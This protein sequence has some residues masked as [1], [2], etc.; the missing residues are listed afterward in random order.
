MLPSTDPAGLLTAVISA[1]AFTF[2]IVWGVRSKRGR[3]NP[4]Q[5]L[6]SVFFDDYYPE[7][8]PLFYSAS[9]K[10]GLPGRGLAASI[11]LH[12][13][14]LLSLPL[15]PYIFHEKI[16]FQFKNYQ[17]KIMEVRIPQPLM[18]TPPPRPTQKRDLARTAARLATRSPA[19][20]KAA[21]RIIAP[22]QDQQVSTAAAPPRRF[23]LPKSPRAR[24]RDVVIQPDQ[25]PET[26]MAIQHSL[27][28]ALLWAQRPAPPDES[29]LVGST[30]EQKPPLRPFS[31][32]RSLPVVQKP[33]RELQVR[34]VQ[35]GAGPVLTF[36]PPK[37][38]MPPANIAPLSLPPQELAPPGELP[39]SALP[40]GAPINLIALMNTP[41]PPASGY[42]LEAGNRPAEAPPS[43][44]T[45]KAAPGA[46]IAGPHSQQGSHADLLPGLPGAID[47]AGA[48]ATDTRGKTDR[49]QPPTGNMG[50]IIVQQTAQE[51]VLEGAEVLTGQPVYTVYFDVPGSPRRWI[52]QYCIPGSTAQSILER[53]EGVVR[54][55]P[56]QS[57]QPPF[58][59]GRIPVDLA[60][61]QP[62]SGRLVIFA[63]INERGEIGNLRVVRG[64]GQPI[65]RTAA[66]TLGRWAFRPA[67]RGDAP[68]AV[69]ALFGIPLQ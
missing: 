4:E 37:L 60:G 30:V 15:I 23:E 6:T 32:P 40:P 61:A 48:A 53:K 36:R 47:P 51:T 35:I 28:T 46:A 43:S 65:D 41:A 31:L 69:E 24:T 29:R 20:A 27:P 26:P 16:K 3:G 7:E 14:V 55:Q 8:T 2:A 49:A 45:E 25:P 59:L 11:G 17:L 66:A 68:V 38:P 64:S 54:V 5:S 56:K 13:L 57:T 1:A 44:S 10:A 21:P 22:P 39:A 19:A 63:L 18:Y 34:N 52:L 67:M 62:A 12:V 9:M 33:N 42:L 58:P 50:V